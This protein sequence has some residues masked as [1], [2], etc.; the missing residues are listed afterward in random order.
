MKWDCGGDL[1]YCNE[2]R[3][4]EAECSTIRHTDCSSAESE[5]FECLEEGF[6]PDPFDCKKYYQCYD[7]GTGNLLSDELACDNY[8]VFDPSAPNND[9]C[10][11]TM[12]RYCVKI[13]C[14]GK[15]QNILMNYPFFP[16]QKGE[17]VATCRINKK[18]LVTHCRAGFQANL[19]SMPVQCKFFCNKPS[20]FQY[21]GDETKYYDC[22]FNGKTWEGKVKSCYRNYYF[23]AARKQCEYRPTQ[24]TTSNTP[25]PKTVTTSIPSTTT[26]ATTISTTTTNIIPT[27][28]TN[29]IP[30]TKTSDDTISTNE[31]DDT[32][33]TTEGGDTTTTIEGGGNFIS[34]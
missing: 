31:G 34:N 17:I 10:R 18:P 15:V 21:V 16:R 26:S 1:P 5:E 7:D 30:P 6:F 3:P 19:K 14:K 24:P 23:N 9:Y 29:I 12:N 11:F 28:T 20:K 27:T 13:D 8:F 25:T 32:V 2:E 33:T 22:V 4:G